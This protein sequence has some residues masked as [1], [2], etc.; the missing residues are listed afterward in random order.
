MIDSIF[1]EFLSQEDR[2][3]P[4]FFRDQG[5]KFEQAEV[6]IVWVELLY[7]FAGVPGFATEPEIEESRTGVV[8]PGPVGG[9][10][11]D[12]LPILIGRP[13]DVVPLEKQHGKI[14]A[15]RR[16]VWVVL[17]QFFKSS[18]R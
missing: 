14:K 12:R 2:L 18:D 7:A 1:Q 11:F 15:Q 3:R 16:I 5:L 10:V 6:R 13:R 4:V 17:D 9:I 8:V